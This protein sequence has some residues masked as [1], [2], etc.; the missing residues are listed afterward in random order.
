MTKQRRRT[1]AAKCGDAG[2][3][4]AGGRRSRL[5]GRR[6]G[7]SWRRTSAPIAN[8]SATSPG[9]PPGPS[10]VVIADDPGQGAAPR[11]SAKLLHVAPTDPRQGL[12]IVEAVAE[13]DQAC[14]AMW[15][16]PRPPVGS[17]S[18]RY[19]RG[20]GAGPWQRRRPSLSRS[21]GRPPPG[22]A[23]PSA[24][25]RPTAADDRPRRRRK[26]S[27]RPPHGLEATE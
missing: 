22:C 23:S 13:E 3:G 6:V 19:R 21:A 11:Q 27:P 5:A 24:T 14:Y 9:R 12:S 20:A 17:G 15:P 2:A 18:R 7:G 10:R 8:A 26:G 16:R 1:E 25:E 4:G